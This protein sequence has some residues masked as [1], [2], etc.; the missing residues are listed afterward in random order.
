M[1]IFADNKSTQ[2]CAG[3]M[4]VFFSHEIL[5]YPLALAKSLEMGSGNKPDLLKCIQPLPYTETIINQPK[6]SAV[7]SEEPIT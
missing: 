5:Q 2:I 1:D 4:Q 6:V 3:N 7:V